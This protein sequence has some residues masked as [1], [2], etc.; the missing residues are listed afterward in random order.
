LN[1]LRESAMV[2]LRDIVTSGL[3]ELIANAMVEIKQPFIQWEFDLLGL[4]MDAKIIYLD[5]FL[6]TVRASSIRMKSGERFDR[7]PDWSL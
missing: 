5:I 3:A 1:I 4:F 7:T 6:L 2:L